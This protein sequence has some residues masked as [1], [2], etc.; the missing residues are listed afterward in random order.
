VEAVPGSPRRNGRGA[1]PPPLTLEG[2]AAGSGGGGGGGEGEGGG[3]G[4]GQ[5][6]ALAR[7]YAGEGGPVSVRI[8]TAAR[9]P[10]SL[11]TVRAC[12]RACV[13]ARSSRARSQRARSQRSRR[14]RLLVTSSRAQGESAYRTYVFQVLDRRSGVPFAV[15]NCRYSE[16]KRLHWD[17]LPAHGL[18]VSELVRR[19]HY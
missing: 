6:M 10:R 1:L 9:T 18:G 13:R 19:L 14:R 3:G 17:Q 12:V 4:E 2:A 8:V 15:F 16:V 5:L 7:L 11:S